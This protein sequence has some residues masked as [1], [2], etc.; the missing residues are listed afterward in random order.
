M[1]TRLAG[2]PDGRAGEGEQQRLTISV[3]VVKS[4]NDYIGSR[5]QSVMPQ[6]CGGSTSLRSKREPIES[7]P[8]K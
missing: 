4:F 7:A 2:R 6:R 3:K 5:E 1:D 8:R